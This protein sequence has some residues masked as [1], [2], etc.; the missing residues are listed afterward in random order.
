MQ[1]ESKAIFLDRDGTINKDTGYVCCIDQLELLPGVAE[2]L[3]IFRDGGFLLIVISNQSGVGRGYFTKKEVMDFNQA[4]DVLLEQNGIK[5]AKYYICFHSPEDHCN[6]RKPSPYFINEAVKEFNI[7]TKMSFL[8]GDKNSD[9]ACGVNGHVSSFLV[10][11][12]KSLLLWAEE[13]KL[14]NFKI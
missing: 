2:A 7:D 12:D 1:R 14:N 5:I 11:A 13:L 8:F 4:L 10:T 3:Q 9:V 6:C